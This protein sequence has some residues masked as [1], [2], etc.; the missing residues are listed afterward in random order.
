MKNKNILSV[1]SKQNTTTTT[2][3][4]QKIGINNIVE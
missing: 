2:G 1:E 3:L 4:F